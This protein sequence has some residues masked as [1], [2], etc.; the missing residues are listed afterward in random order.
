MVLITKGQT[1]EFIANASTPGFLEKADV[2]FADIYLNSFTDDGEY[3]EQV[4]ESPSVQAAGGAKVN[5]QST[6]VYR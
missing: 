3:I 6:L 4:A 2:S 5:N 1:V